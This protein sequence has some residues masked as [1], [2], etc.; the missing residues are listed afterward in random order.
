MQLDYIGWFLPDTDP[1]LDYCFLS[2]FNSL[3]KSTSLGLRQKE[4]EKA[5]DQS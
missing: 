1:V 5:G 3:G 2:L 4:E